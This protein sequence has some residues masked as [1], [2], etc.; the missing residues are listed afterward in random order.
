MSYNLSVNK[1]DKYIH[2]ELYDELT[3]SDIDR[4]L[5]EVLILRQEQKLNHILCDERRLQGRPSDTITFKTATR[6]TSEPYTGIKL[7][8][9]RKSKSE[10]LMFELAA[11][12]RSGIVKIFDDEE[13]A[14]QWLHNHCIHTDLAGLS[15]NE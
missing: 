9:I 5:K 1:E 6:F 2:V 7:A 4:G 11:N 8:I 12:N 13:E 15:V 3:Q 10:E 14:K